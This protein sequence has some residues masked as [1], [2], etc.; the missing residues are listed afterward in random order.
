MG[1]RREGR[2]MAL[3]ALY[4]SDTAGLPIENALKTTLAEVASSQVREFSAH[5]ATGV[6]GKKNQIDAILI[7]YAQ[8]WDIKRMAVIDRNILRLSTYEI[9]HDLET[10]VSVIIDEA[11]EIAK[12]FSTEDSGKFVNGI[13]DKVKSER[14]HDA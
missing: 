10:P 6:D 5:L 13:L 4:L 11:I 12:T 9:I 8:N 1:S 7:R 14:K 3:Q 2:E